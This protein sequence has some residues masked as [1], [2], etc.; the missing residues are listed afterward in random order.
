MSKLARILAACLLVA[1][2]LSSTMP[3]VLADTDLEIGGVAIVA[4]TGGDA[5][6]V[7]DGAGYDFAVVVTAAEGA[8]L[9]VV[10]GPFEGDD[11]ALWYQVNYNGTLGYVFASFLVL[12]ENAPAEPV[13]AASQ[14]ASG[15]GGGYY[16]MVSGT[17]GDG[18]RMRDNADLDAA[19]I[20]VIPEGADVEVIGSPDY[21]DGYAWYPV[22]YAGSIGWVA[23]IFLGDG[24]APAVEAATTPA[25]QS[26]PVFES[27][28]HVQVT[29]TGG[30]NIRIRE[31]YGLDGEIYGHAPSGAVLQ[32]LYGPE[33]DYAGGV[34]YAVDYD[35]LSG[36]ASAD[37]L[38]WTSSP[39]SARR[40]STPA[41]TGPVAASEAAPAPMRAPAA[42]PASSGGGE[43]IVGVAMRYLGYPYVWGGSSPG[44]FDCSGFTKYVV[45]MVLGVNIGP[46]VGGQIGAGVSIGAKNLEPGDLVF[47]QN[48]Y[49]PG[50]S[51]VG[52]YI[53][54]GQMVHAGSERTGVVVSNIW[55]SYWGPKYY[56]A[57]RIH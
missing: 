14:R 7:R 3:S 13:G 10:D 29:G 19:I 53:G 48:T 33:W 8:V 56:G 32:V 28:A 24:S 46:T 38:S 11:G 40:A 5:V 35:G 12:P 15:G 37:Y 39:L 44:G 57:R 20:L 43:G 31:T 55:D 47:F 2:A 25:P 50:L 1:L 16:S 34:W 17:G 30:E 26:G 9:T 51:H 6:M 21:G 45:N 41:A 52:I 54:G 22:S 18:A 42:A 27:G 23:G 49:Q 36:F 4:N